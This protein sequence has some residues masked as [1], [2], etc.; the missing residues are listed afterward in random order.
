MHIVTNSV[1]KELKNEIRNKLNEQGISH[2]TL[3]F[4]SEFE[5]CGCKTCRTEVAK[6]HRHHHHH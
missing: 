3:E 6:V 4:E 2:T 1:T 5:K